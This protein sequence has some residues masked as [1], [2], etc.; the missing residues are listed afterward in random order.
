VPNLRVLPV[1]GIGA[2]PE[3]RRPPGDDSPACGEGESRGAGKRPC[4]CASILPVE[5]RADLPDARIARLGDDSEGPGVVDVS[6]RILELRVVEDIEKF[7]TEVESEIL[8]NLCPL[9]Y[10]EI[11]VV[12]ARAVEKSPVG[13]AKCSQSCVGC[14][15]AGQ[16]VAS[17]ASRVRII[18]IERGARFILLSRVLLD[19]RPDAVRHVCGG[20]PGQRDII[21]ALVQLDGKARR[22]PRDPLNLPAL[23]QALGR[24]AE[25]PVERDGPNI[26]D[27]K[28][29][30]DVALEKP[31]A[32][33]GIFEIHQ[34]VEGR[35]IIETLGKSIRRQ[36]SKIVGF[37]LNGDLRG[38]VDRIGSGQCIGIA[39]TKAYLECRA[40]A[41][42][43]I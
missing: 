40:R 10:S 6:G 43:W 37:A 12:E 36:E 3:L 29:V 31:S 18:G 11:G 28:I 17:K 9:Q 32:Q 25:R 4:L 2:R 24:A 15:G 14:K 7:K 30:R 39:G 38:V 19:N 21:A 13:G 22:E 41:E 33:L 27:D 35:R 16:E 5:L 20:A 26:A 1:I 23:G 42:I 8:F 34:V